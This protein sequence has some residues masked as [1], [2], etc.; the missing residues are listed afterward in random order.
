MGLSTEG[1]VGFE[2]A[3]I[4]GCRVGLSFLILE[5]WGCVSGS[6]WVLVWDWRVEVLVEILR[7]QYVCVIRG[8]CAFCVFSCVCFC[9]YKFCDFVDVYFPGLFFVV[10]SFVVLYVVLASVSLC[11]VSCP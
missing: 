7:R 10:F 9:S 6:G 4:A 8:F 5:G 3:G 1:R 2:V 11:I